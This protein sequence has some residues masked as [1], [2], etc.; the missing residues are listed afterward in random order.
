MPADYATLARIRALIERACALRDRRNPT[1]Y[2]VID[3]DTGQA[4]IIP[5]A[6]VERVIDTKGN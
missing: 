5:A 6:D 1:A 2:V 3:L 4:R